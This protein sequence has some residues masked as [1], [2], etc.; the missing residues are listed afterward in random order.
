MPSAPEHGSVLIS[1][2]KDSPRAGTL[3]IFSCD[4]GRILHGPATSRC[5]EE[6]FWT[7]PPP[8]CRGK[9]VISVISLN[10]SII[11]QGNSVKA[12]II[13]R[14]ICKFIEPWN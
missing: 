9:F 11:F 10:I 7:F 6:G 3:A 1:G 14:I 8:E 12:Q 13:I 4:E 2:T 5:L